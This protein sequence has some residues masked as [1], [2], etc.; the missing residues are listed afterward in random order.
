MRLQFHEGFTFDDAISLIPYLANLGISHLNVSPILTA[1]AGSRSGDDVIDPAAINPELGGEVAFRRLVAALRNAGLSLIVDVAPGHMAAGNG[2]LWWKDVLQHGRKSTYAHFFDIDWE[3]DDPALKDKILLPILV[4]PYGQAL[5]EGDITVVFNEAQDRYEIHYLGYVCPVDPAQRP[6]IERNT[7]NGFDARSFGGRVRLQALLEQQ[8]FRLATARSADD[9]INWRR[10]GDGNDL[11]A[12]RVEEEDVFDATHATILRLFTDGLID[13]VRI[14]HID[15]LADPKGYCQRLRALLGMLGSGSG[16]RTYILVDK[17]LSPGEELPSDWDCDGASG[18]DFTEQLARLLHDRSGAEPLAQ[19][20]AALGERPAT[21]AAEMEA[22]RRETLEA[23][24]AAPLEGAVT[25]LHRLAQ[26]DPMARDLARPALRRGLIEILVHLRVYRTYAALRGGSASDKKLLSDAATKAMTTCPPRDREAIQRIVGWLGG[27]ARAVGDAAL[28]RDTIRRFQLLSAGLAAKAADMALYR[29][30]PLSYRDPGESG[31]AVEA[32]HRQAMG[33]ATHFPHAMLTSAPEHECGEDVRARLAVLSEISQD[34]AETLSDWLNDAEPFFANLDGVRAPRFADAA[35]LFQILVG[36]WP[37]GLKPTDTDGLRQFATRVA[38]WQ[39]TALRA[40]KLATDTTVPN[41]AYEAAAQSFLLRLFEQD[42]PARIAA[43]AER[44][45]PA[46]AVNGLTQTLLKLTV[47]G[48][49]NLS[50]GG[51]LWD[52]SLGEANAPPIDFE[53]RTKNLSAR[54]TVVSLAPDW[55]DGEVKQALIQEILAARRAHF[56]LFAQGTYAP[57][58]AEGT[59][60][61]HVIAFTRRR[62]DEAAIVIASRLT[63]QWLSG[64]VLIPASSWD[65]TQLHLPAGFAQLKW[66]SLFANKSVTLSGSSMPVGEL[67]DGF[68]VALLIT[69]K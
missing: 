23:D 64:G 50:R 15:S 62:G 8:H 1:R 22:S 58:Q 2:N 35:T 13:G 41:Q 51:D 56:D 61:D 44:I 49:P 39:V 42:W 3:P 34:W 19:W 31:D 55:R 17:I 7:L 12:L 29:H 63:A 20:R 26:Q 57:L 45:A 60:A 16:Q 33:R 69:A 68:P 21:F 40:A 37:L 14:R 9:A 65:D 32:F 47:P 4:R 24:F 67:L 59:Q 48:M 6:H 43:F 5:R 52:Q 27:E 36:A 11:V 46:G 18:D 38:G 54:K 66:R 10:L 28:H 30:A 25:A 53:A